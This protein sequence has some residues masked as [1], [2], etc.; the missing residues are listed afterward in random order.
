MD[1]IIPI[2]IP[3]QNLYR[4]YHINTDTNTG[5][6]IGMIQ[7]PIHGI[8]GTLGKLDFCSESYF[9]RKRLQF[10]DKGCNSCGFLDWAISSI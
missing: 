8:G 5:I 9:H 10:D 3:D 6:G 1:L 7:I 2:P 4:Y